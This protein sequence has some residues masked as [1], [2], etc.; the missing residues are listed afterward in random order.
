MAAVAPV[1]TTSA[2]CACLL[3]SILDPL[4]PAGHHLYHIYSIIPHGRHIL[5]T[6]S[7]VR[8]HWKQQKIAFLPRSVHTT[9]LDSLVFDTEKKV[10]TFGTLTALRLWRPVSA[11]IDSGDS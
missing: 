3:R 1:N 2:P 7:I 6:L 10:E 4:N 8:L 5:Q 9:H 11:A